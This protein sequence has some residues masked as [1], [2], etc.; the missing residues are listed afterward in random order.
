MSSSEVLER[1]GETL[2]RAAELLAAGISEPDR[3]PDAELRVLTANLVK[4]YAAKAE[5]G[6][7]AP[8]SCSLPASAIPTAYPMR[9][10]AR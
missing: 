7:R 6:M 3:V 10:C 5:T 9:S 2:V 8:P 4:L 1:G